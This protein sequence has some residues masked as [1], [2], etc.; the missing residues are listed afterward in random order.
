VKIG[1][2]ARPWPSQDR[3]DAPVEVTESA[4]NIF[5]DLGIETPTS[6]THALVWAFRL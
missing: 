5:A 2:N 1:P 3:R 4:G 6:F